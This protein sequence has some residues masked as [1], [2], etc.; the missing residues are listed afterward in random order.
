MSKTLIDRYK[1]IAVVGKGAVGQAI[2]NGLT[3]E[4]GCRARVYDSSNIETAYE[5]YFDLV[6]YAGVKASKIMA[7]SR[8]GQD[9][10]HCKRA[11]DTL[12]KIKADRKILISTI[13]ASDTFRS[14]SDYGKNRRN[15]ERLILENAHHSNVQILRLPAL[16][17]ST[18][19][20]NSWYDAISG[21][22]EVQLTGMTA[23]N[24]KQAKDA[25]PECHFN[26][27]STIRRDSMFAWYNL[28]DILLT[29]DNVL[30][31]D[32]QL[33]QAV[34]YDSERPNGFVIE[35]DELMRELGYSNVETLPIG[36][37]YVNYCNALTDDEAR[38][39]F[40]RT[41]KSLF[42]PAWKEKFENDYNSL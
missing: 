38:L 16:Y 26:I 12:C 10:R 20:K 22:D 25:R 32:A 21:A 36:A 28:D 8:P 5:N 2:I 17:G 6:I 33:V 1:R 19:Y 4:F 13:D 29:I 31:S 35:H 37:N 41:D 40:E 30:Q 14:R 34:S 23:K 27:L 39:M 3:D 42:D 7:D 18:V 11:Y 9:L 24:V 15:I